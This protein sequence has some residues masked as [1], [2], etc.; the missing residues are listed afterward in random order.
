MRSRPFSTVFLFLGVGLTGC[1]VPQPG[2]V[3]ALALSSGAAEEIVVPGV[4]SAVVD[5][6]RMLFFDPLL[7]GNRD[8][9]CSTCHSPMHGLGDGRSLPVGTAAIGV[10]TRLPGPDHRLIPRNAPGLLDAGA[11]GIGALFWDARLQQVGDEPLMYDEGHSESGTPRTPLPEGLDSLLAAQT[12]FPIADRD[13][14][15]GDPDER[16][17][18]GEHNE[19]ASISD[20]D[21]DAVWRAV[22]LRIVETDG[23]APLLRSA[24]PEQQPD[25]LT[26]P[27]MANALGGFIGST[28]VTG[29][30]SFD[31]FLIDDDHAISA[32]ALAGAELF[33][34]RAGCVVCHSGPLLSDEGLYNVGVRPIGRGPTREVHVDRGAALR[35]HGGPEKA[36][37]FKTPRLRNVSNTGPWMHNG[38]YLSLEEVIRH[39]VDP[40]AGLYDYDP[41]D[42]SPEVRDQ[43]HYDAAILDDVAATLSE[44]IFDVPRLTGPEIRDI[45][46]FLE[47]LEREGEAFEM[48]DAVP[49][50]LPMVVPK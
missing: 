11:A 28:F 26:V 8:I 36:Y 39:H 5:F 9:S 34:G 2:E 14:M 10:D 21:F 44:Q 42:L 1:H 16:D 12:L 45:I 6:G 37:F 46:A 48:P 38:A 15:R 18:F 22:V 30:T 43:V 7:S 35:T 20:S 4:E 3:R 24:Y 27:Q 40:V 25:E 29:T 13:E 31:R 32:E 41:S 33:Y 19:L 49:S 17:I 50:G 47:A 23:Y